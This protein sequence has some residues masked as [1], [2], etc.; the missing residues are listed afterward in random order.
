MY[1]SD[2]GRGTA[3][4]TVVKPAVD[5]RNFGTVN[6]I[7]SIAE[8]NEEA[9]EPTVLVPNRNVGEKIC[10]E[11]D[12][13]DFNVRPHSNGKTDVTDGKAIYCWIIFCG[14]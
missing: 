5:T 3:L 6:C 13:I 9:E 12:I 14:I 2:N 11:M 10:V 8:Y 4:N 7:E 1:I